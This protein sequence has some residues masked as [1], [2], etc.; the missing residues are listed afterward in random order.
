MAQI[1][2]Q[3]EILT[4]GDLPFDPRLTASSRPKIGTVFLRTPGL[5]TRTPLHATQRLAW[6]DALNEARLTNGEGPLAEAEVEEEWAHSVDL[7]FNESGHVLIRPDPGAMALAFQADELLQQQLKISKRLI[8]FLNVANDRVRSALRARGEYWRMSVVPLQQDEILAHIRASRVGIDGQPIYYYNQTTGTR[9]VTLKEFD[10]LQA[11]PDHLLRKMLIEIKT[12]CGR[13]NRLGN[14]EIDFFLSP[15]AFSHRNIEKLHFVALDNAE[16]RKTHAELTTAFRAAVPAMLREDNPAQIEWR[17]QMMAALMS[18]PHETDARE[19]VQGLSPEFFL[20]IEWLPGAR[21]EEGELLLD[22]IFT[23]AEAEPQNVELRNMCDLR[24]REFI[25]NY[26]REFGDI[27]Y[28]NI[29]RIGRSLS[30]RHDETRRNTVYIAEV[31][32]SDNPVPVVRII[33]LQKWGIAE[34]LN[35]GVDLLTA[36]LRAEEYTDYILDRRLGCRQL[37]MHLPPHV[38][39]RRISERY[40]GQNN[41]YHGQIY[42]TTYLERDY[43]DGR[44]SDKL[45]DASYQNPEFNRRLAAL[46]GETAAIN[47]LVGR[48][49]N[50][51]TTVLFDDGDEVVL[52]D[53][54]GLPASLAVSD[55]T[56][57]FTNYEGDLSQDTA[58]YALPVNRRAS[59]M[60]NVAEFAELYLAAF[61]QRFE[62][63]QQVYRERRRA[64]DSLFKHRPWDPG[65]SMAY[66]WFHILKRLDASNPLQLAEEIRRHIKLP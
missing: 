3:S 49:R 40:T 65:G 24:A 25:F 46:L 26:V 19:I 6:I 41:R 18:R 22:P 10:E 27:E 59:R 23:E 35:D 17:N 29:G 54:N 32:Q 61:V 45:P 62:H 12:F 31:K 34:H 66:R 37:G 15:P 8:R 9:F 11:L 33:R 57:T 38:Q 60:P 56:G 4:I 13:R 21:I 7:L 36:I 28:A 58:A 44:A 16:L 20:Q 55:H 51:T 42:W 1:V 64:F 43:V 5:V 30:L 48:M 14:P 50:N 52:L 39:T 2:P 47:L 53:A 63:I